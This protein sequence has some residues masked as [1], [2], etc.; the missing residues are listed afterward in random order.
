MGRAN[1]FLARRVDKIAAA[2]PLSGVEAELAKKIVVTGTPV[3]P[4]VLAAASAPFPDF[5]DG[6]LRI[7]ITG[8]S[9]GARVMADVAPAAIEALPQE[10]R[11]RIE[12]VQQARAEDVA[13]VEAAYARC[14]V[15]ADVAPFFSD[16]PHRIASAHLVIAR[17]GASTVSELA[18]IGRAS[19]LVPLPHALDQDQAANAAVLATCGGAEAVRQADFTPQALSARIREFILLPAQLVLR[20]AAAKRVGIADASERLA[21]LVL[22]VANK[23]ESAVAQERRQA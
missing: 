12:I 5:V 1:R 19:I 7:L 9:Q 6:K 11:A 22:S 16:L 14:G 3:R 13:R 4:S 2:F 23:T 18:V 17:S 15:K 10:M 20:A 21:D 8:G